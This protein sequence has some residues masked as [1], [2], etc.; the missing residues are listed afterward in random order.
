MYN[1]ISYEMKYRHFNVSHHGV[2]LS[3]WV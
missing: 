3:Q 1:Q 2:G